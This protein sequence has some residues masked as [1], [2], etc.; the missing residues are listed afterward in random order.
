MEEKE[1]VEHWGEA[2]NVG[3]SIGRLS[4]LGVRS[5]FDPEQM[6]VFVVTMTAGLAAARDVARRLGLKPDA[7][8]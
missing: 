4:D 3:E 2:P 7:A 1:F 8:D 6:E 5:G